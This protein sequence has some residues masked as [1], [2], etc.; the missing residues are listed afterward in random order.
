MKT[1]AILIIAATAALAQNSPT[2]EVAS[3]RLSQDDGNHDSDTNRGRFQTH[4]VTLRFLIARAFDVDENE[5]LGG[6][7]W[8]ATDGWDINAAIPQ[9]LSNLTPEQVMQM[10]RALLEERFH[11]TTHRDP[12][13]VSGY[14]LTVGGAGPKMASAKT[15]DRGSEFNS[16]NTHLEARYVNM[17]QVARRLSRNRDIGK[18]VVDKTGLPA[19]QRFDFDLDWAP[20][21]QD[22]ADKP[23]IFTALQEQVGLKLVGAKVTV[24]AVLIDR[25]E[26][27]DAN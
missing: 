16:H 19:D 2:F 13:E 22:D 14:N 10:L 23:Y 11:L 7:K 15:S 12:R 17:E 20:A 26:R 6:P 21:Q 24:Q 9:G 8:V 18:I 1:I 25:A 5:V 4:N 3:I 27:P